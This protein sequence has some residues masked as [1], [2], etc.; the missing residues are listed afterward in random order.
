M[1]DTAARKASIAGVECGDGVCL[2]SRSQ[3]PESTFV[4]C[5]EESIRKIEPLH[6]SGN[7]HPKTPTSLQREFTRRVQA[8]EKL[9]SVQRASLAE[10][11]ALFA[12]LQHRAFRGEL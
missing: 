9:K 4:A 7:L 12:T 8:V 10:L 5:R 2:L 6:G 3:S 1:Y 11:D